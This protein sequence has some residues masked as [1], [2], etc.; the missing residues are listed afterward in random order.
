[1]SDE[2]APDVAAEG[3]PEQAAG[4]TQSLVDTRSLASAI[5]LDSSRLSSSLGF[6]GCYR[7]KEPIA[8]LPRKDSAS[9]EHRAK[10]AEIVT[11][12]GGE[13]VSDCFVTGGFHQVTF[14]GVT[15]A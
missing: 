8:H 1:M 9:A 5:G 2:A 11:E 7:S 10:I 15:W 12:K 14:G 4:E 3:A 13:E 6:K